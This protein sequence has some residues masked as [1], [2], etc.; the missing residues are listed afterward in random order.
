MIDEHAFMLN[1]IAMI[2]HD[3]AKDYLAGNTS[4]KAII[5]AIGFCINHLRRVRRHI[6]SQ[7]G[8]S[9]VCRDQRGEKGAD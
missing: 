6:E 7:N 5:I 3:N 2:I 9:N 4:D 1:D 8:S